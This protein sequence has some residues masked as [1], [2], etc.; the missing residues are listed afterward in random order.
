M[1]SWFWGDCLF[2]VV[3]TEARLVRYSLDS[4]IVLSRFFNIVPHK[5]LLKVISTLLAHRHSASVFKLYQLLNVK[6]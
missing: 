5:Q 2:P 1:V 3:V 6:L 4:G